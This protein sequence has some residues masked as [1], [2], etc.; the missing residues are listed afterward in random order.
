MLNYTQRAV[1]FVTARMG[2]ALEAGLVM[3][4][5]HS[6]HSGS[7]NV[8]YVSVLDSTTI[9]LIALYSVVAYF[10]LK[11]A[12]INTTTNVWLCVDFNPECLL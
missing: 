8:K 11:Y 2:L 3:H 9:Q 12:E 1:L 4:H 6:L 10:G 5:V 7:A